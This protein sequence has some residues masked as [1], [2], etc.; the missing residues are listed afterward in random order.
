MEFASESIETMAP[1]RVS[2]DKECAKRIL[3]L[4]IHIMRSLVLDVKTVC[5]EGEE[6][7]AV[8]Y[9]CCFLCFEEKVFLSDP[10]A[11]LLFL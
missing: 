4:E 5:G 2:R 7:G 10:F 3:P 6:R 1:H 11:T 9:L 8:G